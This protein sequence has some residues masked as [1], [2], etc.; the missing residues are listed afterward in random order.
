MCFSESPIINACN[1]FKTMFLKP[2][3][4]DSGLKNRAVGNMPPS[5]SCK[6]PLHSQ[7]LGKAEFLQVT[8]SGPDPF[9][10]FPDANAEPR[11][12]RYGST[13]K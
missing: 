6:T 1:R 11:K 8:N 12:T 5:S 10:A 9:P 3:V 4:C 13:P 2:L 7:P